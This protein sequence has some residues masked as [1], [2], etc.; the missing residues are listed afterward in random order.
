MKNYSKQLEFKKPS[1]ILNDLKIKYNC[2]KIN[3]IRDKLRGAKSKEDRELFY[4]ALFAEIMNKITQHQHLIRL[5]EE[6][7]A[8]DCEMLD[9]SEW[10]KNQKLSKDLRK[11]DYYYLQNVQI[12]GHVIDQKINNGDNNIYEII[13]DHL[14]RTKLSPQSGDYTGC[15]L[16]FYISL[17][18]QGNINLI[19]LREIIRNLKQAKFQQIWLIGP[20]REKYYIAEL[21]VSNEEFKV[22]IF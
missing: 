3:L 9:K 21:L 8:C 4:G 5:P 14:W 16:V 7:A 13:K 12:T 15:I 2:Q 11:P 18:I 22:V 10:E 6:D 17:K 20:S 19:K 1:V